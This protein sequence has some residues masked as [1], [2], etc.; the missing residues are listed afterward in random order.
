MKERIRFG[1]LGETCKFMLK[2]ASGEV[3]PFDNEQLLDAYI[4][5]QIKNIITNDKTL[6][7]T[8]AAENFVSSSFNNKNGEPLSLSEASLFRAS[9]DP[10]ARVTTILEDQIAPYAKEAHSYATL[11][12]SIATDPEES[13]LA[14]AKPYI[15]FTELAAKFKDIYGN[16]FETPFDVED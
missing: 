16:N 12:S 14:Y 8:K 1:Q 4:R 6:S 13:S 5:E 3:K 9:I 7:T 15:G 10:V 2:L 11:K